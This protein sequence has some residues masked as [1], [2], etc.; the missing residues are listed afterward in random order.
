MVVPHFLGYGG[1]G[2]Q[3]TCTCDLAGIASAAHRSTDGYFSAHEVGHIIGLPHSGHSPDNPAEGR[4][5]ILYRDT[6]GFDVEKLTA[7]FP[8]QSGVGIC[9]HT[10]DFMSYGGSLCA[11]APNWVSDAS[12]MQM[13][14][15]LTRPAVVRAA[16][17]GARAAANGPALVVGATVGQGTATIEPPFVTDAP[18]SPAGTAGTHAFELVDQAGNVLAA[19]RTT[20]DMH[21]G[22]TAAAIGA[23]LPYQAQATALRLSGPAGALAVLP[24]SPSAPRI[25]LLTPRAGV[26]WNRARTVS[27]EASDADGNPLTFTVQYSDDG[28]DTWTTL[29]SRLTGSKFDVDARLLTGSRDCRV[30]VIASD[31]LNST[32][33]TSGRFGVDR[34]RPTAEIDLA[35]RIAG[36]R[37]A[38]LQA[39][40]TD[41]DD[42]TATAQ[43]AV[44]R[45]NRDGVL[46]RG[47][48]IVTGALSA[49]R[50]TITLTLTDSDGN[51]LVRRQSLSV[52]ALGVP[53]TPTR[54]R[55]RRRGAFVVLT[56]RAPSAGGHRIVVHRVRGNG[57]RARS[58]T[59][60]RV[61]SARRRYRERRRPGVT[62][63]RISACSRTACSPFTELA[64]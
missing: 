53:P 24:R 15:T 26:H 37:Q 63:Y 51:R 9:G 40:V 19:R 23:V 31:G 47:D 57:R 2:G 64:G 28:G 55:V 14:N 45:S 25:K 35:E 56:W 33:V 50:H 16:S 6:V 12:Y 11:S 1:Y 54:L 39:T 8:V 60:A 58:E 48:S 34:H 30:R 42:G 4:M 44:W 38:R 21:A 41:A 3:A 17:A 29:A 46:G 43:R 32:Q 10:H 36:T 5:D 7:I 18:V 20:P 62:G 61:P 52:P 59:A 49:G 27:W 13:F 22:R